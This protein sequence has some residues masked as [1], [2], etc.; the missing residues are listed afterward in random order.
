MPSSS[1]SPPA[2]PL[3]LVIIGPGG[4][5]KGT[6]AR[7]LIERDPRLWLSRSWTTRAPRP[8]EDLA[9]Y[10]FVDRP[11]FE[12]HVKREGFV[13]WAEFLGNLYGTPVP[14][15][16]P[17]K[18]VLLEIDVQGARQIVARLPSAHVLLL[19][20]PSEEHQAAR[21]RGRGDTEDHVRERIETGR[22][23]LSEGRALAHAVVVN[24]DLDRAVTEVLGILKGLR[25]AQPAHKPPY[26][27]R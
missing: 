6:V 26:E 18:D 1:K 21:L 7:R 13:E 5:G 11:T 19:T 12:A 10:T 16:P 8:G 17:G 4:T 22:R 27:E 14:D 15:P 3:T 20:P 23:E 2:D 25:Q 9:S 24:D